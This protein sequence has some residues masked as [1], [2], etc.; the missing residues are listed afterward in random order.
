[1]V[2]G[3]T[4][5]AYAMTLVHQTDTLRGAIISLRKHLPTIEFDPDNDLDLSFQINRPKRD[6]KGRL[7]NRLARW[8]TIQVAS[9]RVTVGN[10]PPVPPLPSR[11]PIWAARI[12][13]DISTDANN[14]S[15]Y[16]GQELSELADELRANAIRIAQNGDS[17]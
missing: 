12:Y 7:I 5:I 14:T 8:D 11:P 15:P 3:A 10:I 17:K 13:V 4:R 1:L 16:T 2:P 6:E 9:L